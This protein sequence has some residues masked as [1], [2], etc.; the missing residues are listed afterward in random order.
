MYIPVEL[1]SEFWGLNPSMA[2][3]GPV[4]AFTQLLILMPQEVL[5]TTENYTSAYPHIHIYFCI[6]ALITKTS[7]SMR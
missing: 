1:E 3:N 2:A 4:I 7:V 5:A 6:D